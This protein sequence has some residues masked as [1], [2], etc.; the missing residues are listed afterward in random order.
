MNDVVTT[1]YDLMIRKP[2]RSKLWFDP[3]ATI[4][5]TKQSH[6]GASVTFTFTGDLAAATTP[7]TETAD[8]DAVAVSDSINNVTMTEY[9]NA[10]V[11]TAKLRGQTHTAVDPIAAERISRNAALTIDTLARTALEATT[12]TVPD[13]TANLT[14]DNVRSAFVNLDENNV[15]RWD[16]EFYLAFIHPRQALDLRAATAV[17]DWRAPQVYGTDQR[18]IFTGEIGEF[19]GFRFIVTNR[20]STAGAGPTGTF[21]SL[22]IGAE[23]LAKAFSSAPGFGSMPSVVVGEVTDKLKRFQ[24]VGWYWLGGYKVFRNESVREVITRSSLGV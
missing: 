15:D 3:I 11:T 8:V 10:V 5:S 16:G 22:F 12:N 13:T 14:A 17:A 1:A 6:R 19:E 4:A 9:G 21:N 24:P 18:K 2:L 7:L 20:V 23:A